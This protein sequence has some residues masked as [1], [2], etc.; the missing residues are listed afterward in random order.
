MQLG[1]TVIFRQGAH[2]TPINGHLDHPAIVCRVWNEAVVNLRILT[3]GASIEWRTSI[4]HAD[5]AQ[6]GQACWRER[7]PE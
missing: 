4:V 2:E 6:P 5:R 3:D 1:D 7:T